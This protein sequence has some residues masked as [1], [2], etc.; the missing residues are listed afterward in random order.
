MVIAFK[1]IITVLF[2]WLFVGSIVWVVSDKTASLFRI[3][4]E[5]VRY[6]F[7]IA[8]GVVIWLGFLKIFWG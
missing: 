7:P 1:I 4:L 6:Y 5:G 3:M 8:I 2:G